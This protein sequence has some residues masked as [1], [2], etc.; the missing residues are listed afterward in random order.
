L[1][2]FFDFSSHSIFCIFFGG[3]AYQT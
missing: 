1:F 3:C 2:F